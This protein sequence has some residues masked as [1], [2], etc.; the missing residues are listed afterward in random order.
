MNEV[1]KSQDSIVVDES[2]R[3]LRELL[4]KEEIIWKQRLKFE[5]LKE[6][7]RNTKYFHAVAT[8][9]R[10][11]NMVEG[12]LDFDNRWRSTKE[13]I[14]SVF[15][16]YF[17]NIYKTSSPTKM[18]KVFQVTTRKVDDQMNADLLREFT[19]EEVR[20]ALYQMHSS[21]SPGPDGMTT[22]FYKEYWSIIG[23]DVTKLTLEF[24]KG[25]GDLK[26]INHTDVVLIPK[27]R[28]PCTLKD[29]RPISLCNVVYK[30]VAKVLA[31]ILK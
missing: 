23:E 13:E 18:E 31:N 29:F 19:T 9:R 3:Q 6:G 5:W 10:R 11:N 24:L 7:D 21:K 12:I 16:D 17:S 26:K 14:T 22:C 25:D 4:D 28:A 1:Q 30:I 27:R 20:Q 8:S 15:L 2:K